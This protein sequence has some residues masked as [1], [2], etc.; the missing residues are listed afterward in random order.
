MSYL[1][2]DT[3]ILTLQCTVMACNGLIL[4]MFFRMKRMY[5]NPS[6]RLLLFV[7]ITDFLH[8]FTILKFQLS[9][10]LSI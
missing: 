1:I 8:A 7:A 10:T 5:G 4:F 3:I 6:L 2:I 9:P